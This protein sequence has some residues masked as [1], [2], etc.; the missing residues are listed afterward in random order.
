M[1]VIDR[2]S[3]NE[4]INMTTKQRMVAKPKEETI[5]DLRAANAGLREETALLRGV[6]DV[7]RVDLQI[8]DD[9]IDKV[10]HSLATMSRWT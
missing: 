6:L 3:F 4:R 7:L 5:E 8:K 1:N 2:F 10:S 9:Q